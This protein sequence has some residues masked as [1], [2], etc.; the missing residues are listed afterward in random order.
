MQLSF[1]ITL[2]LL[3]TVFLKDEDSFGSRMN[4]AFFIP[5]IF[6]SALSFMILMFGFLPQFTR[7]TAK[8]G[9]ETLDYATVDLN[10]S[11]SKQANLMAEAVTPAMKKNLE[12]CNQ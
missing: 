3:G 2:V 6:L 7:F 9:S 1:G 8:V 10:T 4:I 5:R 11:V 12:K